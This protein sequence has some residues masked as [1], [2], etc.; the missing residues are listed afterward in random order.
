MDKVINLD[1]LP[2]RPSAGWGNWES[3]GSRD[4]VPSR[5]KVQGQLLGGIHILYVRIF[6]KQAFIPVS[7]WRE[8]MRPVML[9][10]ITRVLRLL[11]GWPRVRV[12]C[13]HR[14]ACLLGIHP[15]PHH[16]LGQATRSCST[17]LHTGITDA[18]TPNIDLSKLILFYHLTA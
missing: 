6:H 11:Y 8:R 7:Q 14:G 15:Q 5:V 16:G 2:E 17:L 18:A 13:V 3:R 1:Q 12:Q 10:V 9:L 4:Q